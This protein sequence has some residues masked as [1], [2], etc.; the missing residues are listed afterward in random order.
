ANPASPLPR[1]EGQG[2]GATTPSLATSA[3]SPPPSS[4]PPEII[5]TAPEP[6]QPLSGPRAAISI[7]SLGSATLDSA[8]FELGLQLPADALTAEG[9]LWLQWRQRLPAGFFASLALGGAA[10]YDLLE[11]DVA[12]VGNVQIPRASLEASFGLG[13]FL[14]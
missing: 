11:F 1:G 3:A 8:P 10:R 2:E 12:N 9:A 14:F 13:H 6:A 7:S 4:P 5:A